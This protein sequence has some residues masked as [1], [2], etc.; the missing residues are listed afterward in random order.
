MFLSIAKKLLDMADELDKHGMYV[1]ADTLTNLVRQAQMPGQ[2]GWTPNSAAG[3]AQQPQ[4]NPPPAQQ[5]PQQA[6]QNT[7]YPNW[8]ANIPSIK[9]TARAPFSNS[10]PF[11]S[12]QG[13]YNP[14]TG[15]A[16]TSGY[17]GWYTG[18]SSSPQTGQFDAN[19]VK[20]QLLNIPLNPLF[21]VTTGP[22]GRQTTQQGPTMQDLANSYQQSRQGLTTD[23]TVQNARQ[24]QIQNEMAEAQQRYWALYQEMQ[25]QQIGD[26]HPQLYR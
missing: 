14:Y 3:T 13:T 11:N 25:N 5:S 22:D 24:L 7:Q 6:V 15:P 20:E 9:D 2:A 16:N 19:A 1:E 21:K 4:Q 23:Q 18:N 17:Q 10:V 12:P 8:A 26:G